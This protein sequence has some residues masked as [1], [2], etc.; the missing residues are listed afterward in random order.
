MRA[1]APHRGEDVTARISAGRD[2]IDRWRRYWDKHATQYDRQMRF[3]ERVLFGDSRLW[4]C[5]QARGDVLE[6]AIGTG[7]NL[8]FY[9]QGVR[10][11]GI[12]L[13]PAMLNIAR[14]RARELGREVELR[15]G[16][17]QTLPFPDGSFD[18]V[19]CTL[20]LCSIPDD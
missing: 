13:S 1:F 16:D 14:G 11:T 19:V 3:F 7:R 18:T 9:P 15:E 20:S 2:D 4:V 12:D 10:L 5:S 17:A 8:Q 6:V